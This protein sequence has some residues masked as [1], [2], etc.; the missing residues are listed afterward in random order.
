MLVHAGGNVK[1]EG[2]V[3]VPSSGSLNSHP[4][5][6]RGGGLAYG[7]WQM[8]YGLIRAISHMPYA[9]LFHPGQGE[10]TDIRGPGPQ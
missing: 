3:P 9:G 5:S 8:A 7:L 10:N 2:P 6:S 4:R 1:G